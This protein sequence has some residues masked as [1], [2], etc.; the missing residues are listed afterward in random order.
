M[1]GKCW[2]RIQ[3]EG[4]FFVCEYNWLGEDRDGQ[5]AHIMDEMYQSIYARFH[6]YMVEQEIKDIEKF[7]NDLNKSTQKKKKKKTKKKGPESKEEK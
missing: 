2:D 6:D 7:E 1:F 5:I 3:A 4:R